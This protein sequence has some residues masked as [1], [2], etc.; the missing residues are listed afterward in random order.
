MWNDLTKKKV[1]VVGGSSGIGLAT[2][3]AA[4]GTRRKAQEKL[5]EAILPV[6]FA[7]RTSLRSLGGGCTRVAPNLSSGQTV[8][9]GTTG[10]EPATSAVTA[11]KP[12][13]TGCNFTAPIA[14]FGAPRNPGEVLLHP[15]RTQICSSAFANFLFDLSQGAGSNCIESAR[16]VSSTLTSYWRFRYSTRTSVPE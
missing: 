14:T 13:V 4:S 6:Q 12:E 7:S 11:Q 10:L 8:M 9:A 5:V 16:T 15:N 3:Q 1:L 2:A